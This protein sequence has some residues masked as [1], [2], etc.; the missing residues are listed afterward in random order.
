MVIHLGAIATA[1]WIG[2][3]R[4]GWRGV[5]VV[6]ALLAVVVRGYGQ[7]PLTQPWNPYLPLLAWIVVLLAAWAVL[8]GDHADAGP[9]RRRGVALRPDP[10]ART[11]C[12]AACWRSVAGASSPCARRRSP[13]DG[14]PA[15]AAA[16]RG[17]G[18]GDRRRAVAAAAS[19][20][21]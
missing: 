20:T 13:T 14:A 12:R 18:V 3:R 5:A 8:C 2:Q 21:S 15:M 1:L 10:R 6:A 17:V 16:Q 4:A 19:P 11:S 7:V 9:A